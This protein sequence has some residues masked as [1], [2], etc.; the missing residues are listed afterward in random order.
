MGLVGWC[1]AVCYI[2]NL[3]GG[4]SNRSVFSELENLQA[5]TALRSRRG[6]GVPTWTGGGWRQI[7]KVVS[8]RITSPRAKNPVEHA[9][10]LMLR[11]RQ[12]QR[13]SLKPRHLIL[14][15]HHYG[16][17]G[18]A[19]KHAHHPYRHRAS[20]V[21]LVQSLRLPQHAR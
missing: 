11:Q 18:N 4:G 20:L 19:P 10:L 6:M 9:L 17:T 7:P 12:R 8:P 15:L 5:M 13:P 2:R 16:T 3:G 21:R 14:T 1:F